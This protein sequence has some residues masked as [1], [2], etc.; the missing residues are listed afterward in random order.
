MIHLF[1]TFWGMNHRTS[2]GSIQFHRAKVFV[3]NKPFQNSLMFA[4]KVGAYPSEAP[5]TCFQSRPYAQTLDWAGM[6]CPVQTPYP[7]MNICK[8]QTQKVLQLDFFNPVPQ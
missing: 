2:Y 5:I 4:S 3:L 1:L 6:V 8:L 7:I